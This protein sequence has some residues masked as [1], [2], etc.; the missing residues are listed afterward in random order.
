MTATISPGSISRRSDDYGRHSRISTRWTLVAALRHDDGVNRG[1]SGPAP[2]L[3]GTG[4]GT[5]KP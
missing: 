4:A 3:R 5:R 1:M 2:C